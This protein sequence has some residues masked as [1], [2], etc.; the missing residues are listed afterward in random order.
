M[1]DSERESA[2]ARASADWMACAAKGRSEESEMLYLR[3]AQLIRERSPEQVR[4]MEA[5][6]GLI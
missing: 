3:F 1:T 2:I 5:E 4:R 6:K